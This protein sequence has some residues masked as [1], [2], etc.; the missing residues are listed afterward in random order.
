M[1]ETYDWT[2]FY[3]ALCEHGPHLL[4]G[5]D[6]NGVREVVEM[7]AAA[8]D[9]FWSDGLEDLLAQGASDG[10]VRAGVLWTLDLWRENVLTALADD[11]GIELDW[12]RVTIDA[13]SSLIDDLV[14]AATPEAS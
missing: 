6:E 1:A 3:L 11:F 2:G 13:N 8:E 12:K 9:R 4:L 10:D 14:E 7:I 5:I